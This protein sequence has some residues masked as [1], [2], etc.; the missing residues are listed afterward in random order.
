MSERNSVAV[1][2]YGQEYSISAD[3]PREY[4]MR[5]ADYVDGKMNELGLASNI[6]MSSVAVLA[7]VNICDELM[8]CRADMSNL[9]D[10]NEELKADAEKYVKLWEDAKDSL[11]KYK[12]EMSGA[13]G[14]RD[15]LQQQYMEKEQQ[16]SSLMSEITRLSQ[17]NDGLKT[18][19]DGLKQQIADL[20]DKLENSQSAPDAANDMIRQYEIK[21]RDLESSFFEIQMENIHLKNEME[22]L[23]KQLR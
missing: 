23:K 17:L 20:S 8:H 12:E 7:A 10:E 14:L 21:C 15:R 16:T 22:A 3:M 13:A 6:P 11:S 1:R 2:I 9:T 18:A 5:V 19:N 4:I